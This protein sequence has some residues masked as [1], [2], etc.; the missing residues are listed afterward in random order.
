MK[1]YQIGRLTRF[2]TELRRTSDEICFDIY[3][4]VAVKCLVVAAHW[5]P[6]CKPFLTFYSLVT[7]IAWP[8]L[9]I[10]S[11]LSCSYCGVISTSLQWVPGSRHESP[12]IRQPNLRHAERCRGGQQCL[13]WTTRQGI[14][15]MMR[16][17]CGFETFFVLARIMEFFLNKASYDQLIIS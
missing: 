5:T 3:F 9:L 14:K 8:I 4:K 7:K 11:Y 15:L 13:H 16:Q 17:K 2:L 12:D 6:S 10:I 1:L